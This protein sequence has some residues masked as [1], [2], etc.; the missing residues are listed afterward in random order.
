MGKEPSEEENRKSFEYHLKEVSNE[1][2]ISILRY[3]EHFQPHAVKEAIREAIRRGII[4]SVEDL[5][6]E[7]FKPQPLPPRSL[8]PVSSQA[9]QNLAIFKSLCRIF[10]G[11][12]LL[13]V[14]LG[15][16]QFLDHNYLFAASAIVLGLLV[17]VLTY[18]LEKE[19]NPLVAKALLF[20][21]VPAIGYALFRITASGNPSTMD[22]VAAAIII[23][24]L[25]YTSFYLHKL[26]TVLSR[27]NEHS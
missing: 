14:I 16:F 4:Q 21:N 24:V 8:F 22:F 1:E 27:N 19:K 3:R 15:V 17:I 25:L 10:Y 12:G 11:F 5:N 9:P 26:T 6:R 13:P 7:E 2:I 20:L 23:L 18:R